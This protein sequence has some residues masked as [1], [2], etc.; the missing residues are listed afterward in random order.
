M[1]R[2]KRAVH[3]KKHRQAVLEQAKGYYGNSSRSFRAANEQVMHAGQYAFRDRR[4]RKGEF[5][6]LWIQRINAGLPHPNGISYSRFIA[7]LKR[8]ASR[9]TAR[10]WPTSPSRDAAA[11]GARRGGQGRARETS[12]RTAPDASRSAIGNPQGPTTAAPPGAPQCACPTRVRSSSRVRV[13][14]GRGRRAPAGT[15][16]PMFVAR[17]GRRRVDRRRR[18]RCDSADGRARPRSRSTEHPQPVWRWCACRPPAARRRAAGAR[19]S[20]SCSPAWPTP[21][22][23]DDPAL[24]EAA[25]VDA[26]VPH[27]RLASTRA[28]PRSVRAVG[29]RAVPRPRGRR[30]S[31]DDGRA[32]RAR[33]ASAPSSH[34]GRRR[35]TDGRPA[36]ADRGARLGN[37]AHGLPD[38]AP[39][40][41]SVTIP[42]AGRAES[43]N[44]GDGRDR[45][46]L[47]G[48]P[49][50]RRRH[51]GDRRGRF[52]PGR[53]GPAISMPRAAP[54][55][56]DSAP[57]RSRLTPSGGGRRVHALE[58]MPR[59]STGS[60]MIDDLAR[61]AGRRSPRST[62]PT[63]ST[64]LAALEPSCSASRARSPTLKTGLGRLATVDE[65]KAAGPGPQRGHARP[66][67]PRRRRR[68]AELAAAARAAQLAAERLDLTEYAGAPDRGHAAPRH[69]GV[70][71]A[72]GR[73]RRPRLPRRRG[74]RGRERLAT[75]SRRST[76]RRATRPA[77][78]LDT[79][80]VEPRRDAATAGAAAHPHLAGADP[81]RCRPASRRSTWWCPAGC[82]AARPPTPPTCRCSTRSRASSSTGA[83]RFADLAGTIE[84]FT[85]AFFG[86]GFTVAP[87]A[88]LL[89]VHR[90]VGRVR[91]PAARRLVAR[92]RRLRHGAPQRAAR[93]RASTP[94]SG[95]GSRSASAS[96]AW[97]MSATA[98]T[99]SASMFANDIRFLEQF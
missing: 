54:G 33:R 7:G 39:V 23:R 77:A 22:T 13:L 69:P 5:R 60:S 73:V 34:A 40:D 42:H 29:R 38:D 47:R 98:S 82:S 32:P 96:T 35:Y 51:A 70:G 4:A 75:T 20:S 74:P 84:A 27:G 94:R 80:F 83:S 9:S 44:V 48:R 43:L 58:R 89:P 36:S 16:R 87:A 56:G 55:V 24:A 62:A 64:T 61:Q 28:T 11:F 59:H 66:S 15:S 79:L 68:R 46:G 97:P 85:K 49:T 86:P 1:A 99:T 17:R 72:R 53:D 8:P 2:V 57:P 19:R 76:C 50:Q 78:M 26:V 91:H 41:A 63:R 10:S 95:A 67:R 25:G 93:R 92:A 6:R 31:L 37:E 65:K 88:A 81:R 71:A 30:P 3:A 12:R 52:R 14:V 21:A 18:C 90:A 45:A